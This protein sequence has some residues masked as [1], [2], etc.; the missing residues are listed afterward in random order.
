MEKIRS[1]CYHLI[2]YPDDKEHVNAVDLITNNYNYAIILHDKDL[3]DGTNEL[4]KPH[5]HII[6]YFSNA[7]YLN[8]IAEE[9]HIK[10]NYIKTDEIK[11]GLEYLIHKNHKD[12]YQYSID[13]V[14]GPLK[15]NL[16]NYLSKS[17]E[18]E[19]TSILLLFSLIDTFDGPI[20][21]EDFIPLVIKNNLWSFFRRSQLTW[22]KLIEEHNRKYHINTGLKLLK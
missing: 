16:L 10:P 3:I 13:E 20:Y 6:L 9:L 22:F 12:K 21:L 7:R 5:W 4:K 14:D 15:E 17:I 11:R 8:S 19:N 18:N 2:L 1:R